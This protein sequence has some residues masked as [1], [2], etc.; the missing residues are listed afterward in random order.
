[1]I[2]KYKNYT[3]GVHSITEK[4]SAKNLGLPENFGRD[5][6][7][8][9][10]MDKSP[11]QIVLDCEVEG[12]AELT[13]DRC[14]SEFIFEL[15]NQFQVACFF[16]EKDTNDDQINIKF[17]STDQDKIDIREETKEYLMLSIPMKVL[18]SDEC[19]GLCT[20]CGVN[21]NENSCTCQKD[22]P[23]SVWEPLKKLNDNL[24]K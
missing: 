20:S 17:L 14:N 19:K 3:N 24:N 13:C 8:S 2:I 23:D 6:I 12:E 5:V 1:M 15:Q 9:C 10:Q 22:K 18:C 7:F 4:E 21:L 16:E 11:H